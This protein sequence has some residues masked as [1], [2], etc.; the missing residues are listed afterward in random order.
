LYLHYSVEK[1]TD[2]IHTILTLLKLQKL[3]ESAGTWTYFAFR[4]E[5][6]WQIL[7][8]GLHFI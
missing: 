1:Y 5:H 8:Y 3:M 2:L 4:Q 7:A 6:N